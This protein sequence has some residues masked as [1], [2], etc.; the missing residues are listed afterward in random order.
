MSPLLRIDT[1]DGSVI[2]VDGRG[3]AA[4]EGTEA[5]EW[6]V[7]ATLRFRTHDARYTWLDGAL[8]LWEGEF[9]TIGWIGSSDLR[10]PWNLPPCR[11]IE[12]VHPTR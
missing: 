8:G 12:F 6:R 10:L 2:R 11:D 7:A 5:S 1:D 3:F 9:V 4:R